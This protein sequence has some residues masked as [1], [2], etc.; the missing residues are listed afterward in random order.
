MS[1]EKRLVVS[2]GL[3]FVPLPLVSF[4][5]I[6]KREF[7]IEVQTERKVKPSMSKAF[8]GTIFTGSASF[9]LDERCK[10]SRVAGH[11]ALPETHDREFVTQYIAY[12]I[13]NRHR[14]YEQITNGSGGRKNVL[15]TFSDNDWNYFQKIIKCRCF[16]TI[17][18]NIPL[19]ASKKS[20]QPQESSS[21]PPN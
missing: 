13:I 16:H 9:I 8:E 6:P 5:C 20:Q 4:H 21:D 18:S 17:H 11:T 1:C 19:Q 2:M 15:P 14:K 12:I 7:L 10:V 3:S